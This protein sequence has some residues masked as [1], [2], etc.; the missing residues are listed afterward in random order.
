MRGGP[1]M[2]KVEDNYENETICIRF[3]GVCPT[4]PGI[5]GDLLFCTRGKSRSPKQKSGC[6][7]GTCDVWDKYDLTDFY[8]CIEGV[9]E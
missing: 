9:E 3:C 4:Y 8:F 6:I 7:C 1:K 5:K 2:P